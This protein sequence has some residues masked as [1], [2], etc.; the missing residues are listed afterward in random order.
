MKNGEIYLDSKEFMVL[1]A[2][3]FRSLTLELDREGDDTTGGAYHA[4]CMAD[5]AAAF[6]KE[7]G[8]A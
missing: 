2:Y 8:A 4:E 3:H 5:Y 1:I 7:L 6:A